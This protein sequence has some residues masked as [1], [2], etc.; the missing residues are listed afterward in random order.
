MLLIASAI[1]ECKHDFHRMLA[2]DLGAKKP[3][4]VPA[5]GS[6]CRALASRLF[7][8]RKPARRAAGP[9]LFCRA[10]GRM[11]A[12]RRDQPSRPLQI[13]NDRRSLAQRVSRRAAHVEG[14]VVDGGG[15]APLDQ[16]AFVVA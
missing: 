7:L 13:L 6:L 9:V 5:A 10:P 1:E 4:R 12:R 15:D 16:E 3:A 8:D 14:R 11:I 2:M